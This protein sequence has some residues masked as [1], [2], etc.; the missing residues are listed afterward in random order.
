MAQVEKTKGC[1]IIG[2][3]ILFYI[4]SIKIIAHL[5]FYRK[6]KKKLREMK[7]W[8]DYWLF[9]CNIEQILFLK[10]N[11]ENGT[12]KFNRQCVDITPDILLKYFKNDFYSIF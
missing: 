5:G 9:Q 12:N 3:F 4:E 11:S 10:Q 8:Y 6:I 2:S 1:V 7:F